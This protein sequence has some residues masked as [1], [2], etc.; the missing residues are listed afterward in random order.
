[1]AKNK[2]WMILLFTIV[3]YIVMGIY[4][5][6][7]KLSDTISYFQWQYFPLLIT[8]TTIE[9]IIRYIKWDLFLKTAGVH[10][11]HKEN[12]FVFFS[13]LSMIVTPGKL[14]EIWKSWLIR[15][16]SGDEI[17]KTLPVVIIDRLTDII[18]LVLLSFIGISYYK[19]G[20]SLLIILS[21]VCIGFYFAIRSKAISRKL[22][23]FL[24]R[25]FGGHTTNIQ[26]MHETFNETMQPKVFV[27]LSMLNALAWFFEC[28]GL[29]F[30][31]IGF[32]QSRN[33][34]LVTFIFSF[35]TLVGGISMV[36]GGIGVAE[37]G[38]SGLLILSGISPALSV[39]IALILR[40]GSFWYG[41]L[42]GFT[43]YALFK[44]RVMK[45]ENP[46]VKTLKNA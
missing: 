35:S 31:I 32:E 42:L 30:V 5:D 17:S 21:V 46:L 2:I 15:D 29:Y 36:P 37:V 26:L 23:T 19:D 20:I 3:T 44:T 41:A 1:M 8:L 40:L 33:I 38:I 4:V 25:K 39:G 10:L 24:E 22:K 27:S 14:G 28:M 16:I 43:V 12:L 13:G 45:D 11:N 6:F 34:L 18:S 9:Y 7:G